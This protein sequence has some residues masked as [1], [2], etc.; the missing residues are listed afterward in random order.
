MTEEL[1]SSQA[2]DYVRLEHRDGVAIIT[3]DHPPDRNALSLNMT[4][5]L[6]E[7]VKRVT[8]AGDVGALIVAGAGPVFSAGGSVDDLFE[9][10]GE[11]RVESL[12]IGERVWRR[13]SVGDPAN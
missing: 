8:S 4:L 5:A 10:K 12:R 2:S 13:T 7:V 1:G 6:T 9:P 11:L 3:L